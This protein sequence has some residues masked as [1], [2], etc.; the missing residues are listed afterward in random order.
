MASGGIYLRPEATSLMWDASLRNFCQRA[1]RCL[2]RISPCPLGVVAGALAAVSLKTLFIRRQFI[3]FA[4]GLIVK[5][6]SSVPGLRQFQLDKYTSRTIH[7]ERRTRGTREPSWYT[8]GFRRRL[9]LGC[10]SVSALPA[11]DGWEHSF[12][13]RARSSS[14]V[15]T[16]L[17]CV[18]TSLSV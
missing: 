9:G 8:V 17:G 5:F 4:A 1:M 7:R 13:V 10:W 12:I 2:N 15:S 14:I 6:V 18:A 11:K 3:F 16:N